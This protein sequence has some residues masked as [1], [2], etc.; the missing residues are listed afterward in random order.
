M[1]TALLYALMPFVQLGFN[2]YAS[3]ASV[4]LA[5][6]MIRYAGPLSVGLVNRPLAWLAAIAMLIPNLIAQG[7]DLGGNLLLTAREVVMLLLMVGFVA[8]MERSSNSLAPNVRVGT[9]LIFAAA[10]LL[11][12]VVQSVALLGG[13]YLGP[14]KAWF[15]INAG[16]V[17]SEAGLKYGGGN[18]RPAGTY[19]EPSYLAFVLLCMALTMVPLSRNG[20]ARVALLLFLVAGLL[21]RSLS[22]VLSAVI[23]LVLPMLFERRRGGSGGWLIGAAA[24]AIPIFAFTKTGA[25]LDRLSSVGDI[26]GADAS[27]GARVWAPLYALPRYLSD[28]PLGNPIARLDG[29]LPAYYPIW[30]SYEKGGLNN[31]FLNTFYEYG[32]LAIIVLLALFTATRDWRIRLLLLCAMMFNGGFFTVDKAAILGFTAALYFGAKRLATIEDR[33]RFGLHRTARPPQDGEGDTLA[34]PSLVNTPVLPVVR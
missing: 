15:I 10:A 17:V 30:L 24:V 34:Q 26:G 5:A 27:T 29:I 3:F 18:V 12:V 9:T 13:A 8:G 20:I 28:Y 25:M 19:G 2:Y 23:V 31:A 14:P 32:F 7:S 21:S 33:V 16:A 6:M 11:T 22:F 1:Y 4:M